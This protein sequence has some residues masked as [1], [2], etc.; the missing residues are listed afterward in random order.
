VVEGADEGQRRQRP[1]LSRPVVALGALLVLAVLAGVIYIG[2][3]G[4]SGRGPSAGDTWVNPKDGLTYVWIS[5]GSFQMGAV[6]G[7][8]A[9][10]GDEK[11]RHSVTISKG[12]WLCRTEVTVGAYEKFCSSTG[13]A[14]PPDRS[15]NANWQYK[16]H[17]IVNV[18]WDDAVAYCQWVGGRLPT[19]AEWEYA[20]RAGTDSVYS[21]GN[22]MDGSYAWYDGN[23]G[24]KTH[25][26]GGK[27]PNGWGL[28]DMSGNVWEW[29]SDWYDE[30][31]DSSSPSQDPQGPS[32][33]EYRAL[34]GGSW[35]VSAGDLRASDRTG[36]APVFRLGDNGFRPVL[37]T[38]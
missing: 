14:M 5:P 20:A 31:Y 26:V 1:S 28:Y 11:P 24:S 22:S 10:H 35:G 33:G 13:R 27:E 36:D 23:S 3:R 30:K 32:S 25:P 9:A 7:D 17:P 19:E 16:D 2:T 15:F 8:G 29:C 12:F 21:W 4:H 6:P 37:P 34:R 18:N 38:R